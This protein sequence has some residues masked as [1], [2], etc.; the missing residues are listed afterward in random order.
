MQNEEK[1][2]FYGYY[3]HLKNFGF[4]LKIDFRIKFHLEAD[5]KKLF[6]SKKSNNVNGH[7]M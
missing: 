3:Y 5:M 2:E 6:K 7:Q 1:I 4:P